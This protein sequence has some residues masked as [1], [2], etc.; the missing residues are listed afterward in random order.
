MNTS[1]VFFNKNLFLLILCQGLYLT[2]N[3]TFIAINGLVGFSLTPIP[4]MATLP[5]MSY[6]V[7]AALSTSLV[8]KVQAQFGRKR[9]FQFALI[10]ASLSTLLC[11]YAADSKNF[12]LLTVGTAI[13]GYYSANGLLYRFVAPELTHPNFREKAVSLLLTGGLFGA[14][15]GPNMSVWTKDIFLTPFLGA[16]LV[17][18]LAGLLGIVIMHFIDFPIEKKVES[19]DDPGRPLLEIVYQPKFLVALICAALSY[20]MMNLI[21]SGTPLAM[22][23][24]GFIFA[25][26]ATVLQWHVIG[27]FAPGFFSG[28]LIK[29]YGS[30][31]IMA[32]GVVLNI[33]A[34]LILLSG[35][36]FYHFLIPLFILGLAW[37]FL[38]TAA[39]T[40]AIA[41]YRPEEK[42]K[43]QA[44]I[45]FFVFGTMA[46]SSFSSG[47]LISTQGWTFI[48]YGSLLPA[49]IMGGALIWLQFMQ[50]KPA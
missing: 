32:I 21:M 23:V 10:I 49:A 46:I 42:N 31:L 29:R 12:W 20:G 4:W 9:S 1:P 35:N 22:E 37:N 27:M 38:F 5:V 8:A 25:D 13:A 34:I 43:S 19:T 41:A 36:D 3:V 45:N 15:F 17:L 44:I 16:Y 18:S 28:Y 47:A 39:T 33:I 50:K 6:V 14:V 2:N 11:A 30:V 40:L 24:C 48:N 7:G 26:T